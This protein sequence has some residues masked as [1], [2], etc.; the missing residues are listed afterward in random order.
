MAMIPVKDLSY[1]LA[2]CNKLKKLSLENCPLDEDC[3][4]Y[5]AQNNDLKVLN[6][7][8]CSGLTPEG[9]YEISI[10]CVK[11]REW[12]LAWTNL[13]SMYF[14]AFVD[15]IPKS[16]TRLNLSGQ[17]ESLFDQALITVIKR[18]SNLI[19]LD[20]SDCMMLSRVS[21]EELIKNCPKLEHLHMSRASNIPTECLKLLKDM[22]NFKNLEIFKTLPEES[23]ASLREY[24]PNVKINDNL[25]STIARPTVGIRRTSIWGLRVRD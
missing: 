4:S 10:S 20:I 2:V 7:A 11:L 6:M 21:F 17:R 18:C 5:I 22:K 15:F 23:L 19:E 12:N 9:L 3:C 8:M 13:G 1:L 24:L 16:L 14:G 25:F